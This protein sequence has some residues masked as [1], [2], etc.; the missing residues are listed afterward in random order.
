MG[1]F[2][3]FLHQ[4]TPAP[5]KVMP[6]Y[7][8]RALVVSEIV[9]AG[10][11][12]TAFFLLPVI[13]GYWEWAPAAFCAVTVLALCS[14]KRLNIVQNF[15]AFGAIVL[16]WCGWGVFAFG[17]SV[18]IQ[19]FLIILLILLFFNICISPPLKILSAL[20][21]LG[22]RIALFAHARRMD[23]VHELTHTGSILFQTANSTVFFLLVALICILLSS[24][25]Q[26][27]E[28]QLR[29]DNEHLNREAGTDPL[30]GLPNRREMIGIIE[31]F[32]RENPDRPFSV[33]IADIDFFKKVNDTYGHACGDA[34]LVALTGLFN[35]EAK[36]RF[37][38]CRWGG[39]EFCFFLPDKNL[40]EAGSIM[41]DL[42][43]A[44]EK[45]PVDFEGHHFNITITVGVEETDFQSSLEE[46]LDSADE[47][48]YLGKNSG[49]NRVVV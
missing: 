45:M 49:R 8:R 33:A 16:V 29:L 1:Y 34:T 39:E 25:I 18:G 27:T 30:T 17:W 26:D 43:F 44:V 23:P 6:G 47:K 7:Y 40:D 20:A 10:Y 48:L 2:S 21:V 9:L 5:R 4:K 38:A 35:A 3:D 37:M 46:L 32:R 12:L 14:L 13:G 15:L 42:N 31:R 24:S 19:H 28:R 22:Y 36:D 41:N 11:F